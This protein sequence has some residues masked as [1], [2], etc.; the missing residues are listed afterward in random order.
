MTCRSGSPG[1]A[2]G[3]TC[4]AGPRR[5]PSR[6]VYDPANPTPAVGGAIVGFGAGI[7]DNRKLEARPD[8]LTFTNDR[9]ET[10]LETIGPARATLYIRSSLENTDFHATLCDV[11]PHGRSL[12]G[13]D[14]IIRLQP[15]N[16]RPGPAGVRIVHIQLW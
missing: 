4:P 12:N 2:S 6:N 8:V 11:R 7:K 14:G 15:A 10:D 9:L 16:A 13:C 1:P 5:P 3:P